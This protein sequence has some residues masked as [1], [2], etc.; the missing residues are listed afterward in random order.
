ML[1]CQL[2][3]DIMLHPPDFLLVAS[4]KIIDH[5]AGEGETCSSNERAAALQRAAPRRELCSSGRSTGLKRVGLACSQRVLLQRWL[6]PGCCR[7]FSHSLSL[8]LAIT[9]SKLNLAP[10]AASSFRQEPP[11]S[12]ASPTPP[13]PSALSA[14]PPQSIPSHGPTSETAACA[15]QPQASSRTAIG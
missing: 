3:V 8:T 14:L 7:C 9:S 10:S 5:R 11:T 12:S 2:F 13:L 15:L 4:Q 6:H 1:S